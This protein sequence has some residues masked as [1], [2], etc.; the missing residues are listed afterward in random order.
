MRDLYNCCSV[1]VMSALCDPMNCSTLGF[2]D[3]HYPLS[4]LKFMS[5]ESVVPSNHLILWHPFSSCPQFF[6]PSGSFLM[7]QL[8]TSDSQSIASASASL[9]PMNNQGWFLLGLIGLISLLSKRFLRVIS[10]NSLK[11]SIFWHSAFFVVQLS[12]PYMTTGKTIA[13]TIYIILK[14]FMSEKS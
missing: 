8:F 9:L 14:F 3:H 5:I 11:A 13:L 7:S 12:H 1:A 4:F 10:S 2:S 6:P